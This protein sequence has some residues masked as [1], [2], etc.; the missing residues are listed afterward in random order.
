MHDPT[1]ASLQSSAQSDVRRP[2]FDSA[3]QAI[4]LSLLITLVVAAMD[5]ATSN[6]NL[7]IV[8]AIP[9]A[10][11]ARTARPTVIWRV[12]IVLMFLSFAGYF[13]GPWSRDTATWREMF[14]HYRTV[15]RTV[16]A[17]AVLA[18]ASMSHFGIAVRR[19]I[20]V[21]L[22]SRSSH[23]LDQEVI[24]EVMA[25]VE[26]FQA[27]IMS[28]MAVACIAAIDMLLP[29]HYNPTTLYVVPILTSVQ[30]RSRWYL[31]TVVC[32]IL[33]LIY[34]GYNFGPAPNISA[35]L[36]PINRKI[37]AMMVAIVG[38]FVHIWIGI[39]YPRQ[40]QTGVGA[41]STQLRERA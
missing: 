3:P 17:S 5:L 8:Y 36:I 14:F 6:L 4:R 9:M 21:R 32:I 12:A 31:W 16:G 1:F 41:S 26:L 35:V 27:A 29:A 37:A 7:S 34:F 24:Q 28:I 39:D 18:I 22:E 13:I 23:E 25:S 19:R 15:N 40:R 20:E 30:T 33:G 10:L 2:F 38:V 11:C